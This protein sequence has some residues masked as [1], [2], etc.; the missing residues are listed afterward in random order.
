MASVYERVKERECVCCIIDQCNMLYS[1]LENNTVYM[2]LY[3]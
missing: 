2:Y 1:T 3:L